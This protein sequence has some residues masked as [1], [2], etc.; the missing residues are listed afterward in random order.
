MGASGPVDTAQRP[1]RDRAAALSRGVSQGNGVGF[2]LALP[3][4]I[5]VLGVVI[6]PIFTTV[7]LS[8]TSEN[9]ARPG[10]TRF[11]GLENFVNQVLTPD[12]VHAAIVTAQITFGGLLLQLPIGM[13]LALLLSR[14]LRVLRPVRSLL[15]LPMML[16]PVAIALM[17]ALLLSPDVG[18]INL[19]LGAL[20]LPTPNWLGDST[21][22]LFSIIVISSWQN[23]GFVMLM[24]LAG[25]ASL[26][27]EPSEAAK[28]DGA[29]STQAFRYVTLPM[30]APVV[31]VIVLIR[32]IDAAKMFDLVLVL[33]GGGPGRAT[34]NL[35]LIVYKTAFQNFAV[36]QGAALAVA[37]GVVL[38]PLYFLWRR[39]T[40][41]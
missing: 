15:L 39:A 17:W 24:F 9:L 41:T 22:A 12:Y 4:S 30:L 2:W 33:T 28:I 31:I 16:T 3:A 29:S 38:S 34:E 19:G 26:P 25:L 27:V 40:R 21:G 20:G 6:V 13:G 10:Q 32:L 11:V 35:N 36:G 1:Q 37:L 23:I 14:E 8:L 18:I 5:L 7:Y